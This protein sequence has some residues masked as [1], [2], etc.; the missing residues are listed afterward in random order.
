M[1]RAMTSAGTTRNPPPTPRNPVR[2]PTATPHTTTQA[3]DPST[4]RTSVSVRVA[5][6]VAAPPAPTG[7]GASPQSAGAPCRLSS[8]SAA[9]RRERQHGEREQQ[10]RLRDPVAEQGAQ[11]GRRDPDHAEAGGRAQVDAAAPDAREGAH[12]GGHPHDDH[13]ARRGVPGALAEEVDERR[14]GQDA[15]A[16]AEA[17]DDRPD[18]ETEDRRRSEHQVNSRRWGRDLMYGHFRGTGKWEHPCC[19]ITCVAVHSWCVPGD[20]FGLVPTIW[21]SYRICTDIW[22]RCAGTVDP[23][24]RHDQG[25]PVMIFTQYYLDCLSQAS[26]LIGDETSRQ[27]VVVDPRR[28]VAEYLDRRRGARA[29][30]RRGDRHPLPRRLPGRAPRTG[31]GDGGLDR[32]RRP[33]ECGVPGAPPGR[34]GTHRAGRGRPG[35]LETPGHTPESI[36][37]LV[38]EHAGDEVPYGVLTG[39]ALFIGDVGRPDLLASIGHTADELG[40]MLYASVQPAHDAARPRSGSSPPTAPARPA[41]RTSPPS[42]GRRSAT[43]GPG[44]TRASRW[45]RTTSSLW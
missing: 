1:R 39:D 45:T 6:V 14:D 22:T 11:V 38:H 26:Y 37:V 13:A 18:D 28:D 36:S 5:T 33:G 15:T 23:A 30:D 12:H 24:H 3:S 20:A 29:A 35:D 8:S 7:T 31:G 17:A 25:A 19:V 10:D 9:G 43:S 32:F 21:I 34:R 41:G 2:N 27:A 16:A 44:T 40:R 42:A 4:R